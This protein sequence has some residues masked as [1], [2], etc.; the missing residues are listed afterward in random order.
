MKILK[1]RFDLI[2]LFF[3][4]LLFTSLLAFNRYFFLLIDLANLNWLFI[5]L[6]AFSFCLPSSRVSAPA[7][8]QRKKKYNGIGLLFL[9][10]FCLT[11]LLWGSSKIMYGLHAEATAPALFN[12]FNF[13]MK[14]GLFPLGFTLLIMTTGY[15]F[16]KYQSG[17]ITVAHSYEPLFKN[18]DTDAIGI[19]VNTYMRLLTYF[20]IVFSLGFLTVLVTYACHYL[21]TEQLPINLS[22]NTM[23]SCF[24]LVVLSYNKYCLRLLHLLARSKIPLWFIF[25]LVILVVSALFI[26]L[27]QI[28]NIFIPSGKESITITTLQFNQQQINDYIQ[29]IVTMIGFMFAVLAGALSIKIAEQNGLGQVAGWSL[30]ASVTSLSV[31]YLLDKVFPSNLMI[32]GCLV[33]GSLLITTITLLQ[34]KHITFIMRATLPNESIKPRSTFY[35]VQMLPLMVVSFLSSFIMSG[36]YFLSLATVIIVLPCIV[37]LLISVVAVFKMLLDTH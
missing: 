8:L 27:L 22:F 25:A 5:I 31:L 16:S 30:V 12:F 24:L 34:R 9:I 33:A 32:S 11:A 35:L 29:F 10:Q 15:Y 28:T 21:L 4:I 26:A 20:W 23:L 3:P 2:A 7:A 6:V 37:F 36:F 1:P 18:T 17:R 13:S 14:S 19:V